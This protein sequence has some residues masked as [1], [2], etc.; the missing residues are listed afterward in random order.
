MLQ[1]LARR[2]ACRPCVRNVIVCHG[3]YE[4]GR[5]EEALEEYNAAVEA[6]ELILGHN[7]PDTLRSRKLAKVVARKLEHAQRRMARA[8]EKAAARAQARFEAK[9]AKRASHEAAAAAAAAARD[10]QA[11]ASAAAE[12]SRIALTSIPA[13]PAPP[14]AGILPAASKLL[15]GETLMV[16]EAEAGVGEF[17]EAE[18]AAAVDTM[19]EAA[20][21]SA[22]AADEGLVADLVDEIEAAV[23]NLPLTGPSAPSAALSYTPS[24][25]P[26]GQ[27]AAAAAASVRSDVLQWPSSL[28]AAAIA[29]VYRKFD[30][31]GSGNLD[32]FEL[33]FAVE[34]LTA[35][36]VA[37]RS[38][39]LS[40]HGEGTFAITTATVQD[41]VYH[42]F[43]KGDLYHAKETLSLD[44]FTAMIKTFDWATA[45]SRD[46]AAFHA[47]A[48][49][50][51]EEVG[52]GCEFE[53]LFRADAALGFGLKH[54]PFRR[55][56]VVGSVGPMASHAG[57][58]VSGHASGHAKQP[59]IKRGDVVVALNGA[60]LGPV[61]DVG[62]LQAKIKRALRR[63]LRVT[64]RRPGLVT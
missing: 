46:Q 7:H 59:A 47:R 26:A 53:V 11:A 34:A 24:A 12:A 17:D 10:A 22:A 35:T 28:S 13:R 45:A 42:A 38:K 60:P 50:D 23:A 39:H 56:V 36:P 61:D 40:M 64:F 33:R 18:D 41:L 2:L 49:D 31:D 37:S 48:A 44:E 52:P 6:Q 15:S 21:D 9:E 57:S 62:A 58:L 1:L 63:P 19:E 32:L 29:R 14:I 8:H 25:T 16:A 27:E 30:V 43:K 55:A 20:V 4:S 3:R 54:L 51:G 5:F